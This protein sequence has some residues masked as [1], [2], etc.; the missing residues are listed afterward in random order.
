[1][2]RARNVTRPDGA[3]P[4]R[5]WALTPVLVI[6]LSGATACTAL[7]LTDPD[8]VPGRS[9]APGV[10]P[11]LT[12]ATIGLVEGELPEKA[13]T[14]LKTKI[15][16]VVDRWFEAAYAGEYPRTDFS[17]AY[18]GF[19]RGAARMAAR[20]G[21]LM[22]NAEVAERIEGVEFTK[23]RVRVDVLAVKRKAVGVTARFV[24][25]QDTTGE[26]EQ[27]ERISGNLYLTRRPGGWKIF[28]YDAKR[29]PR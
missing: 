21:D 4:W 29:G 6:G 7:D 25:A 24:L 14:R 9:G 11:I 22:S 16:G 19:S 5:R 27:S 3:A 13:R 8:D 15:A 2:S 28:G 26:L 20:D 18:P 17:G 12:E 1:M 10:E 23:R